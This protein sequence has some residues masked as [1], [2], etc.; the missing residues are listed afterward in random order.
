MVLHQRHKLPGIPVWMPRVSQ[1]PTHARLY[2][3]F[4]TFFRGSCSKPMRYLTEINL[5]K[6]LGKN[7]RQPNDGN[8]IHTDHEGFS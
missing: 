8:L 2:V 3:V 4:L 7:F 1:R 5:P 6:K